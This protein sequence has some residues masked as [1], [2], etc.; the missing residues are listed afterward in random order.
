MNVT[1]L[2]E[3]TAQDNVLESDFGLSM[4]IAFKNMQII[5]DVGQSGI[6]INNADKLGVDYKEVDYFV[7]SHG[8][9]DHHDRNGA[10]G[11]VLE[12]TSDIRLYASS[13]IRDEL[14][15]DIPNKG[16]R[17]CGIDKNLHGVN[18]SQVLDEPYFI[19]PD[20]VLEKCKIRSGFL[21]IGNQSLY[22]LVDGEYI[23]DDFSHEIFLVIKEDDGLVV[24]TGCSHTGITNMIDSAIDVFPNMKVKAVFGGLHTYN[25]LTKTTESVD[26][27][28]RLSSKIQSYGNMRIYTGHCTGSIDYDYLKDILGENITRFYSGFVVNL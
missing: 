7:L 5:F 22:K 28:N 10:L 27:L 2:V 23:P 6:A 21:P 8:H 11:G 4:H 25:P 9:H 13:D 14:Y 24:F 19:S 17:Y 26:V 3:D 16:M 20:I 1:T 18:I 15:V 12:R